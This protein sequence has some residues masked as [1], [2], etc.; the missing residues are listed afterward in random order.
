LK[1]IELAHV[2]AGP[3]AGSL[4]ADLGADVVK[5]ERPEGDMLRNWPPLS[6]NERGVYS[7]CFAAINRNKRSVTIDFK[8][9]VQLGT[10][11]EL[12]A[13]ADVVIENFRPGVLARF[14]LDAAALRNANPR[15]VYCSLSGYGQTG[16][17]AGKGAFDVTIQAFSGL[18]SV[19]G[20]AGEAPVK[21]GVPVADFTAGLYAGLTILAA[22]RRR[23][24]LLDV[25]S[26]DR[27]LCF[28]DERILR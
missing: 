28:A 16:P 7:E 12:C 21:C 14:G 1:V 10:L 20:E 27:N 23:D 2:A 5:I 17:S 8:D 9:P 24:R 15:L 19:T 6:T 26:S 3:F 11:R 13:V 18:M 22:L 25:W 4:L